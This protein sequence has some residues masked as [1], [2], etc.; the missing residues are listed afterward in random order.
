M[1]IRY[2]WIAFAVVHYDHLFIHLR[3]TLFYCV[4]LDCITGGGGYTL[5][6][7]PRCWTYETSILLDTN[8]QDV[9]PYNDYYEYF[10]PDYKLHLPVSNM[11]NMNTLSYLNDTCQKVI[12]STK[13]LHCWL[14][15]FPLYEIFSYVL[16]AFTYRYFK[17][18]RNHKLLLVPKFILVGCVM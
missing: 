1:Y 6:N 15:N 7:V 16:V 14:T 12:D 3:V 13:F 11:E 5:R 18:F 10:S 8:I 9:L 4:Y 2:I 17:S